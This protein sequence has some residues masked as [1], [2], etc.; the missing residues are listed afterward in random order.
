[1]STLKYLPQYFSTTLNVG[2]GIDNIQTAGIVLQSVSGI[3]ITKPGQICISY[4]DPLDTGVAEWIDYTSINGSNELV[5]AVRGREGYSAH[6]HLPGATIQFVLSASHINDLND[7]ENGI[8]GRTINT[9]AGGTTTY[10]L[11]PSPAI[12]AYVT[13][14]E[15]VIKMNAANTGASTI[16]V[17]GLGAKNMTKGGATALASGDLLID[18]TY[19]IIYDGT[20]F[21][22]TGINSSA[23]VATAAEVTTGTD[24]TKMVTPLAAQALGGAD[25]WKLATGTW[26]YASAS[27]ITVPSGAASIYQKG[28]RIK[29]TQT[30]VKYGVIVAVA[31]TLLT[32]AVNTDYTV[33]NAAISANYFSHEAN[34]L[35]YPGRFTFTVTYTGYSVNPGITGM[36]SI[37]NN[38]CTVYYGLS[39]ATGTS[40]TTGLAYNLPIASAAGVVVTCMGR[41]YDNSA[42]VAN[43]QGS[44]QPSSS[45]FTAYKGVS[46]STW[47]PSGGKFWEGFATYYI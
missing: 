24:N 28:D 1:M 35:G 9:T 4:S 46:G 39:G 37:T 7:V 22:V 33:A 19:K 41:G 36:Y 27:T 44:I 5:G 40:N 12:T 43:S 23:T 6:N 17:S 8:Q 14:Q 34:P 29:W 21:Q 47:T 45:T 30:T 2:G 25:G 18:A 20:Q 11:T 32:I 42:E 15:F 16:N 13:G 10:T 38:M 3:D 26:T 31:D